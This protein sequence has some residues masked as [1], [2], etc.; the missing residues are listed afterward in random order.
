[1]VEGS[2]RATI[3]TFNPKLDA[4]RFLLK[5]LADDRIDTLLVDNGSNNVDAIVDLAAEF[6]RCAV[7]QLG[8]NCGIAAAQNIGI[9]DSLL[10]GYQWTVL[11]D[12]D[13]R[14]PKNMIRDA[15]R[16]VSGLIAAGFKVAAAGPR[17]RDTRTGYLYPLI[18]VGRFRVRKFQPTSHCEE[19]TLL[20][21]SGSVIV[22]DSLSSIG[23]M[24]E[25]LF[26][27]HV[28]TE[29]CFRAV[30][31]GYKIFSLT[32]LVMDHAV[33]DNTVTVFGRNLPL[34]DCRRRYLSTRNLFYLITHES[35][36]VPWKLKEAI[37]SV[38]KLIV[39][40]PRIV[41][42]WAHCRAYIQ[43]LIDGV[44]GKL[45]PVRASDLGLR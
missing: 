29:W 16:E 9:N 24:N 21:A 22:N 4:L 37:T 19:V 14:P 45:T 5:S 25:D 2:A 13:S 43:G 30:R 41:D 42:R 26:I 18:K 20:I 39:I 27:D 38:V 6:D 40:L 28:D 32:N 8:R 10:R 23:L 17:I 15:V 31:R 12:Q 36:P 44:R 11:L 34:H 33:G 35:T 1:M 3:P 7:I